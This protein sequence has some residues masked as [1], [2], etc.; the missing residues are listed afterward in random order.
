VAASVASEN[1]LGCSF[2]TVV[3]RAW[4]LIDP[5]GSNFAAAVVV[6]YFDP[7]VVG[8]AVAANACSLVLAA[9]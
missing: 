3:A 8:V 5:E 9:D 7:G 4:Q 2:L 6:E 1:V